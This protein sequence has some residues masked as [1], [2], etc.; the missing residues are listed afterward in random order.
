VSNLVRKNLRNVIASILCLL[1]CGWTS[2]GAQLQGISDSQQEVQLKCRLLAGPGE[3]PAGPWLVELR[4]AAGAPLKK[5]LRM[6]GD[7]VRFKNLVPGIYRIYLWG[8]GGRTSSESIDLT[9][10]PDQES[11]EFAKELRLP[12]TTTRPQNHFQVSVRELSTPKEASDEMGKSEKAQLEGDNEKV[13]YHLK[14]AIEIHPTYVNAW[15]N[16]GAHYHRAG[17]FDE[18]ILIFTK[19]TELNPEFYVAWMNLGGSFVATGRFEDAVK[20]NKK[21]VNL[22]PDDAVANSQLGLSYYYLHDH[23]NAKKFLKRVLALD[24]AFVNS[25]HLFLAQ[26]ALAEK[27]YKDAALYM[28]GYLKYHPNA[29]NAEEVRHNMLNLAEK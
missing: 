23:G 13:V 20:A 6:A 14:R 21:A 15:N 27:S 29:A 2:V 11:A 28:Q 16:L 12:D 7:T 19:V 26:I 5:V 24:P 9:P 8:K 22:N 25:P 1:L 17:N 18:A 10:A 4:N 3:R